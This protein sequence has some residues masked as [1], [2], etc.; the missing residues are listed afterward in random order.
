MQTP[1]SLFLFFFRQPAKYRNVQGET[2]QAK[3]D[4]RERRKKEEEREKEMEELARKKKAE[5]DEKKVT[6]IYLIFFL[7]LSNS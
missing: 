1:S 4:E 7:Q 2:Q 6:H 3:N 5:E